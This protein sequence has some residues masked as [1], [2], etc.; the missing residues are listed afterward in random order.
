[1]MLVAGLLLSGSLLPLSSFISIGNIPS[2]PATPD[3]PESWADSVL[4]KMSLD[5][6]IGQLFMISAYSNRDSKYIISLL[7][8]IREYHIGGLCFFQGGAMHQASLTNWIQQNSKIPLLI[9]MDA[10]WGPGMRLDSV[11]DLPCAMTLGA[12]GDDKIIYGVAAETARQL[13][14]LGVQVNFAPVADINNNP[15]NPVINYRSF[16][17]DRENVA[18]KAAAYMHGLQDNGILSVAKHFPGH[19]DTGVDSHTGLPVIN[20]TLA[21]LDSVELYPFRRLIREGIKGI[22]VGHLN[23]P[24]MDPNQEPASVSS[25]VIGDMLI[26]RLGF[27]GLVFTDAMNMKAVAGMYP[28][29]DAETRALIAGA[30]VILMPDNLPA[31]VTAIK[32]AIKSR[33]LKRSDLDLHVK[34]I[35]ET[36]REMHLFRHRLVN[37]E[38]AASLKQETPVRLL[39]QEVFENALTVLRN[40]DRFLPVTVLD[41][42]KIASLDIGEERDS[43]FRQT[44]DRYA[45]VTHYSLNGNNEKAEAFTDLAEKLSGFNLIIAGIHSITNSRSSDY[46]VNKNDILFLRDLS[47]HARVIVVVFGSPYSA[48]Y[49]TGFQQVVCA[50]EDNYYSEVVVP[51]AIFGA[52]GFK[53]T[54]PVSISEKW[55]CGSGFKTD[56]IGRMGYSFPEAVG[57]N[58][59]YLR[60]IDTIVGDAIRSGA[61]PGC[62][63]LVAK[64]GK[65]VIDKAYGY[66]TYD[67][68]DPVT[69]HSIYDLASLTKVAATLQAVMFLQERNIIDLDKKISSYLPELRNTNKE[70]LILRDILTHQSGLQSYVPF[71]RRTIKNKTEKA[72]Y[73]SDSLSSRFP[74]VMVPGMYGSRVLEDSLWSWIIKSPLRNRHGSLKPYTYHYSDIGFCLLKQ[75]VERLTGQPLNE[76]LAQNLYDPLG[77]STMTFLPTT[78]FP[79][80]AIVPSTVDNYFRNSILQGYVEDET[81]ALFGGV[82]G[83]AG[84]FSDANDLAILMQMQLQKGYYGGSRY[85][86]PATI[87]NFTDQQYRLNRRGLGWDKPNFTNEYLNHSSGYASSVSYG[88]TGYSGTMVW[89]DPDNDLVY[90]FLSNRTYP[91]IDNNKLNE[92]KVRKRIQTVIY[93]A[94]LKH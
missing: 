10:E 38:Q 31:A 79:K 37:I 92:L 49:F 8:T 90:I 18:E 26:E 33:K 1:M 51:Q 16:G 40:D 88:H 86:L 62:Q 89:V 93:S 9:A 28:P 11:P 41:T 69:T 14:L 71:W 30:D 45:P 67:K 5:E 6:K 43:I 55:K 52:I 73:Y 72:R 42:L 13:K 74:V 91:D 75:L 32:N 61:T 56:P 4:D 48:R 27:G 50:Y 21:Y 60:Y 46:G 83:H 22:M 80:E 59:D 82:S 23:V 58:L 53:G 47:S 39:K 29:G 19:G 70:D 68:L 3:Q 7:N 57:F 84:L 12:V 85:F 2:P 63:V 15:D 20:H 24:A 25:D 36:K 66:Y 64:D 77:L 35:L 65:V 44:L 34:K 87:D 94:L 81:A 17:E 76:F 78:K 54:S